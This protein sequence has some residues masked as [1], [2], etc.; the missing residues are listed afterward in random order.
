MK[1]EKGSPVAIAT[2][3]LQNA[4]KSKKVLTELRTALMFNKFAMIEINYFIEKKARAVLEPL[5]NRYRN[6]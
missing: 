3:I 4:L 2:T 6:E 1:L 5:E